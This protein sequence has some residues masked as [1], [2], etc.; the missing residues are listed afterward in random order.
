V[1]RVREQRQPRTDVTLTELLDRHL[2]LVHA[3]DTTR[4]SYRYA[5]IKH[6]RPLLGHRGSS[7]DGFASDGS[8]HG[9]SDEQNDADDSQPHQAFHGEPDYRDDEPGHE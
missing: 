4:R 7:L 3:S 6:L 9:G 5:V 2:T 8:D 1:D